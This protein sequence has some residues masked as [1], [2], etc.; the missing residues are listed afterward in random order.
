MSV[1]I[2]VTPNCPFNRDHPSVPWPSTLHNRA[3]IGFLRQC[4]TCIRSSQ[5]LCNHGSAQNGH[6]R[7]QYPGLP[8]TNCP[9]TVSDYLDRSGHHRLA[10]FTCLPAT[11]PYFAKRKTWLGTI[12]DLPKGPTRR[13]TRHGYLRSAQLPA[14][15]YKKASRT[16]SFLTTSSLPFFLPF[17]YFIFHHERRK[18][19][20]FVSSHRCT[21]HSLHY[22]FRSLTK[23][24]ALQN[25]DAN[26]TFVLIAAVTLYFVLP[27]FII[28]KN[29]VDKDGNS[30]PP[31]PLMRLPYLPDYPERTL[32]SW[33][34]KY[35]PLYSFYLG[36][37]LY[38]VVSDANIARELLVNNGAI[39]S[40]RK[41][42][43]VKNQ[44]I[45]KGRAITAS[46]YGETWYVF[47]SEPLI[48]S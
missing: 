21:C 9:N 3:L 34:Q 28:R 47:L 48:T 5:H 25:L 17:P 12:I 10:H 14:C 22:K 6:V 44:T 32:H 23:V 35:G 16:S 30:I 36:N 20:Y 38:V 29:V 33:A 39:F 45:L 40:S 1:F 18:Q 31:G 19:R 43:F 2:P 26:L 24:L 41:Q 46:P 13:R 42:Y 8:V 15:Q 27:L 11:C 4:P 7:V 37:Q